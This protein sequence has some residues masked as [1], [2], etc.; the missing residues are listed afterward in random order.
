ME[1]DELKKNKTPDTEVD[2]H[3]TEIKEKLLLAA[4]EPLEQC[5]EFVW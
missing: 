5:E 4:E 1:Q 3:Q 2:L